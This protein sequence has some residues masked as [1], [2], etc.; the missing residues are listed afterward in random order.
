MKAPVGLLSQ[1]KKLAQHS[2]SIFAICHSTICHSRYNDGQTMREIRDRLNEKGIK[3]LVGSAFTYTSTTTIAFKQKQDWLRLRFVSP[4]KPPLHGAAFYS[5][6]VA[7]GRHGPGRGGTLTVHRRP[8]GDL[9]GRNVHRR[10]SDQRRSP[11][12][13]RHRH[14]VPEL[15]SGTPHDRIQRTAGRETSGGFLCLGD[16]VQN[17]PG[18][19][20]FS[21]APFGAGH[22]MRPDW[23][24]LQAETDRL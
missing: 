15:R 12:G 13:P 6:G 5:C 11:E 7:L 4:V 14:G 8:G 24:A 22:F 21:W 2:N 19:V 10:P 20:R 16:E 23:I 9:Q 17:A 1:V 18:E 3:N